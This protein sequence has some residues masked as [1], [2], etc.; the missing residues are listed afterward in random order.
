MSYFV[1]E[2]INDVLIEYKNVKHDHKNG[3][4]NEQ[5]SISFHTILL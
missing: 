2:V 3:T 4:E 1:I 5:Y